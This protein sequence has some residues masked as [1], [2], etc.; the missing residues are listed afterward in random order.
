MTVCFA[1]GLN[2]PV[3]G[4]VIGSKELIIKLKN[5][6]K[7]LGGGLWHP[8]ILTRA[9]N[10]ALDHLLPEIKKDN[11]MAKLLASGLSKIEHI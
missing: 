3:G 10:Y 7:G 2:C 6:R 5:I 8:G 1:K 9:A 11:E 4:A